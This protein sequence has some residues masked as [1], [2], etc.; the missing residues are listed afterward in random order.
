[1]QRDL[2]L[3]NILLDSK[4]NAKICD[5]GM[6]CKLSPNDKLKIGCGGPHYIAPEMFYGAYNHSVDYWALG[7]CLFCLLAGEFPFSE[8]KNG[9]NL[10]L[11]KSIL[12]D[13]TPKINEIRRRKFP[14]M[15]EI[16]ESAWDFVNKLLN[17]VPEERLG[18]R[19]NPENIREHDFFSKIDWAQL[20]NGDSEPPIKPYVIFLKFIP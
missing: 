13:Y 16:S 14:D 10:T 9:I 3:D 15:E 17:K 18:S 5:F 2:K 8:D 19:N 12:S 7:I 1:M 20:E 4:G 11:T 6:C